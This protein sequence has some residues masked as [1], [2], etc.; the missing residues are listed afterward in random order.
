[1]GCLPKQLAVAGGLLLA[2]FGRWPAAVLL[3]RWRR[4]GGGGGGQ[5]GVAMVKVRV[6]PSVV[7]RANAGALSVLHGGIRQS[8]RL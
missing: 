1:M 3:Q 7:E 2:Q 5:L 6:C 4:R 8:G